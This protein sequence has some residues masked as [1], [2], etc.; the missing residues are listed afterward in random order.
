MQDLEALIRHLGHDKGEGGAA[1]TARRLFR[2]MYHKV[3]KIYGRAGWL[4]VL[5]LSRRMAY[6]QI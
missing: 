1:A 2:W 3:R 5:K 6:I 4:E